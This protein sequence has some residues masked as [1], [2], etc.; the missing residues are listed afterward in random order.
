MDFLILR[1]IFIL[2]M[3]L[4]CVTCFQLA[5]NNGQGDAQVFFQ[6]VQNWFIKVLSDFTLFILK[7]LSIAKPNIHLMFTITIY[8]RSCEW[9]LTYLF[10]RWISYYLYQFRLLSLHFEL[11]RFF[12]NFAI[13]NYFI[14]PLSSWFEGVFCSCKSCSSCRSKTFAA[15]L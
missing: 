2:C 7:Y 4:K 15:F 14:V 6:L 12:A 9:I 5:N 10:G 3:F 11:F 8:L 13:F 1:L